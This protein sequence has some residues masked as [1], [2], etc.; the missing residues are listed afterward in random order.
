[1][2][3]YGQGWEIRGS[4]TFDWQITCT[5]LEQTVDC[6]TKQFLNHNNIAVQEEQT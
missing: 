1:M 4:D 6:Q 3:M 5:V 2:C